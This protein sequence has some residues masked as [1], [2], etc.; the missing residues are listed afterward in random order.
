MSKK[1]FVKQSTLQLVNGGYLVTGK[2]ETPVCNEKFIEAQIDAE[3]IVSMANV[4]SEKDFSKCNG[5]S[6]KELI[7]EIIS[8]TKKILADEKVEYLK[9]PRRCD[10]TIT[11][12]LQQEALNFIANKKEIEL[13]DIVNDFMQKFNIIKEFEEFGLYFDES[14]CKLNKIY[15]IGEIVNAIK[16]LK[17]IG[18]FNV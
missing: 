14:I 12:A 18:F 16:Q 13:T 1:I 10:T 7:G 17:D 2:E 4:A 11:H 9:L 8:E 3:W 5:P 6:K 15:T